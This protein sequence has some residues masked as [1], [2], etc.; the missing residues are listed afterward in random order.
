MARELNAAVGSELAQMLAGLNELWAGDCN[1]SD[2]TKIQS[3]VQQQDWTDELE[4]ARLEALRWL[5]MGSIA[6]EQNRREEASNY[7]WD[8]LAA[9]QKLAD[10][11]GECRAFGNLGNVFWS[12]GQYERALE[13]Y[14]RSLGLARELGDIGIECAQ[15]NSWIGLFIRGQFDEA[16]SHHI[17]ALE[18][19]KATGNIR[20]RHAV[21]KHCGC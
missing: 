16:R 9:F 17:Q 18:I 7:F 19:A 14:E 2:G 1:Q 10:T 8:A 20:G 12:R 4:V 15:L 13:F 5:E 3:N 21:G 11:H 6:E